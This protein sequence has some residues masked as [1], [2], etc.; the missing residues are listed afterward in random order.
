M[1][2]SGD[3]PQLRASRD[4]SIEHLLERLEAEVAKQ[5]AALVEARG[6]LGRLQEDAVSRQRAKPPAGWC[7]A[8]AHEATA[9]AQEL[10]EESKLRE[11]GMHEC[12]VLRER[13]HSLD[14]KHAC[15]EAEEQCLGE[16]IAAEL[17]SEFHEAQMVRLDMTAEELV[18]RQGA[19][20]ERARK[21]RGFVVDGQRGQERLRAEIHAAEEEEES[22]EAAASAAAAERWPGSASDV[23]GRLL[24]WSRHVEEQRMQIRTETEAVEHL[25]ELLE[26]GSAAE[27]QERAAG[28]GATG[29]SCRSS[30]GSGACAP[31]ANGIS[32]SPATLWDESFLGPPDMSIWHSVS[33][34]RGRTAANGATSPHAA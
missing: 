17:Q 19:W 5:G 28:S 11:W 33:A 23:E 26:Q 16:E 15:F 13:V 24:L 7:E 21:L 32:A 18:Q 1:L 3:Q 2:F 20:L 30:G 22:L 9:C 8:L 29:S 34:A 25:E 14:Q 6:E 27:M 12:G 31:T 4:S 10:S